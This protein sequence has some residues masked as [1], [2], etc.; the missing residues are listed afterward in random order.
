MY[1]TANKYS[2]GLKYIFITEFTFEFNTIMV[3]WSEIYFKFFAKY[4]YLIFMTWKFICVFAFITSLLK[5]KEM[6]YSAMSVVTVTWIPA[7]ITGIFN[8]F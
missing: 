4:I 7:I 3:S 8:L 5:S 1:I 2:I 6:S